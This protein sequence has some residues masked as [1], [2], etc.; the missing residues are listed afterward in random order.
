MMTPPAGTRIAAVPPPILVA[1]HGC[2]GCATWRCRSSRV[3]ART[4]R[5]T[6]SAATNDIQMLWRGSVTPAGSGRHTAELAGD[7]FHIGRC[8]MAYAGR[9][10]GPGTGSGKNIASLLGERFMSVLKDGSYA[11]DNGPG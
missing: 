1:S 8:N 4:A 2:C 3:R 5:S 9:P 10:S 11:N 6:R 7:R